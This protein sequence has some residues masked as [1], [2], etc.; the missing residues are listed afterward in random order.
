MTALH[1]ATQAAGPATVNCAD[2][3]TKLLQARFEECS[4]ILLVQ[5]P[6]PTVLFARNCAAGPQELSD[7]AALFMLDHDTVVKRGVRLE[8]RRYEVHRFYPG[9]IYGRTMGQD[10]FPEE[11]T[12]VAMCRVEQSVLGAQPCYLLITYECVWRA[13]ACCCAWLVIGAESLLDHV[14]RM[15]ETSA[16]MVHL[17]QEFCQHHLAGAVALSQ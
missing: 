4:R 14:C 7:L 2:H 13:A 12:G 5:G 15:P 6:A 1:P 17:L 10:V 3:I 9:L 8:G 16:K 11:S